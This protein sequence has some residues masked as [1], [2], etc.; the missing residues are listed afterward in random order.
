MDYKRP[1]TFPNLLAQRF[2]VSN[3]F[4]VLCA[5]CTQLKIT[6]K[7]KPQQKVNLFCVIDLC[8]SQIV[9][10]YVFTRI[11]S[12]RMTTN[13]R[14]HLSRKKGTVYEKQ[15]TIIHSD[16]GTE[17][18][19]KNWT[20]LNEIECVELS[21]SRMATPQDN[22]VIE[23][24]F[25][26][27]KRDTKILG[28]TKQYTTIPKE[29]DNIIE[30]RALIDN[31]IFR[32]NTNYKPKRTQFTP[33]DSFYKL[34]YTLQNENP[35]NAIIASTGFEKKTTANIESY[36][37]Q[38]LK[39]QNNRLDLM[40]NK[41]DIITSNQVQLATGIGHQFE[42]V[43][44]RLDSIELKLN[45]PKKKKPIPR[46]TRDPL[47]R[48]HLELFLKTS[49]NQKPFVSTRNKTAIILLCALGC[50]N[51]EVTDMKYS[52]LKTLIIKKQTVLYIKKTKKKV[53][54][55]IS[56]YY[57]ELLELY[58]NKLI[59]IIGFIDPEWY[60]FTSDKNKKGLPLHQNYFNETLN[61]SLEL[62]CTKCDV[63]KKY[64]THSGRI[65]YITSLLQSGND[66]SVVAKMV[67]HDD[68]R[69]TTKY[70]RY[71]LDFES[72]RDIL[73]QNQI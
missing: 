60:I 41:L 39:Q 1:Y 63:Q 42:K 46:V 19:N 18:C 45:K 57:A 30:L 2:N 31:V 64:Q 29:I 51:S 56:D 3:P 15:Q 52:N 35:Q 8:T 50:R 70:D 16:R 28:K 44:G 34:I 37:K 27:L 68:I 14:Q 54:Q 65:A 73:N 47:T 20:S 58:Y 43:M 23:R 55:P 33:P 40:D 69:S 22:A 32:Y 25:G 5:D 61:Q 62:F 71:M 21:M 4:S 72:K 13:V 12:K 24:F 10:H 67:N 17:F 36:K 66:I 11:S 53:Y 38:L 6:L 59:S 7:N 48:N 9:T 49:L 26:T